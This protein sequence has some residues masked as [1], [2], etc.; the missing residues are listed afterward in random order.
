[1]AKFK[2]TVK[3]RKGKPPLTFTTTIEAETAKLAL[4]AIR[5]ALV[6]PEIIAVP[7][8]DERPTLRVRNDRP[9]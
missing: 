3:G 8:E 2:V 6:L 7:I 4:N 9:A 1:M 5:T